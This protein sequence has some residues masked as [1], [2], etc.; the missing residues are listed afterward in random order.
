QVDGPLGPGRLGALE[1]RGGGGAAHS[2]LGRRLR[3]PSAQRRVPAQLGAGLS[4]L[5]DR[6]GDARQLHQRP[7][8]VGQARTPTHPSSVGAPTAAPVGTSYPSGGDGLLVPWRRPLAPC[9]L[10][11]VAARTACCC[12]TAGERVEWQTTPAIRG[13]TVAEETL[14]NLLH[15]ERTFPPSDEFASTANGTQEMYDQA[16]ADS[17]G[18]WAEQARKYLAWDTDFGQV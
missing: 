10:P 5:L 3:D 11:V 4:G 18:F 8:L 13:G 6:V 12:L 14:S 16:A 7:H 15:E 2:R 17:E 1:Q 9:G